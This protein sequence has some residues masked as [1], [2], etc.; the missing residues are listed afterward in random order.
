M[1]G[2][3]LVTL[4]GRGLVPLDFTNPSSPKLDFGRIDLRVRKGGREFPVPEQFLR[5][6]LSSGDRLAFT[7]P[8]SPD[9]ATGPAE[10]VLEVVLPSG[11]RVRAEPNGAFS[12]GAGAV[13][14]GPRGVLLPSKPIRVQTDRLMSTVAETHD[15]AAL[16]SNA[17]RPQVQLFQSMNNGLFGRAGAPFD[18]DQ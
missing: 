12:Y 15:L 18:G 16:Y 8:S 1:D 17:G 5:A 7:M 9:G 10:I 3:T 11:A 14:F 13:S 2:G 6:D 4:T